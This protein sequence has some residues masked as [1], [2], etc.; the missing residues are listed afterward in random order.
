[1]PLLKD[2]L[3]TAKGILSDVDRAKAEPDFILLSV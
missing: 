3:L 1:M 2:A